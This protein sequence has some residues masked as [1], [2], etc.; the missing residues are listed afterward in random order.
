ML[1][2][3]CDDTVDGTGDK[4]Y[5]S[6]NGQ[7]TVIDAADRGGPIDASGTTLEGEALA[8]SDL[9][10]RVVVVNVWGSWCPP[11]RAETPDLVGAA[12][13][14]S[15]VADYVG[16]NTREPEATAE[17]FV[18]TFGV[19]FPSFYDP[20]GRILLA[21]SGTLS[22][23]TIPATVVLDTEGRVAAS[24]IGPLPSQLTLTD[25][26]SDVAAEDATDG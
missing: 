24:I 16:V 13:E 3:G 19:T 10:G 1:L 21:F 7:I 2:V 17:S 25:L 14:T 12:A 5:I 23:R 11:C 18:R 26:V 4:G 15:D 20:D 8:L 22:P 6:G 9:R